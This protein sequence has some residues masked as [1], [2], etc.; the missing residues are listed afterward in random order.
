MKVTA[1]RHW[2]VDFGFYNAIYVRIETDEGVVG[3]AEVAMRRRTRSVA[4]LVEELGD[5][6]VGQDPMRIEQLWERMYRDAFLGGTLL[7]VGISAIDMALWDLNGR[8]LGAPVHRLL[9]GRFRDR[10][11]IYGHARAGGSP[12]EFAATVRT[13]AD[14]GF[15]AVKTTLPGFYQK[16]TSMHHEVPAMV[17][18]RHTETEILPPSIF[19]TIA[20]WFAAAR[21]AVGPHFQIGLDCHGR[22]SVANAIRLCEALEPYDLLFVEE[23]TPFERPD[24]LREVSQATSIPIAAGERWG[25]HHTSAPFLESHSVAIAQPDVSL[26][27]GLT[28]GRKIAAIAEAHAIAIAFHNPFGPLTSAATMHLAAVLPNLLISECMAEPSQQVLWERY[29]ED[30]PRIENGEWVVPDTPGLGTRL[31]ID[32]LVKHPPNLA[33]DRGGTR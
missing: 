15:R 29:T 31:R 10:V 11:P 33:Y 16:W 1:V 25:A 24:W 4:A 18:A 21:E 17:P 27:G 30:P 14:R 28:S 8:A 19:R 26:C 13:W 3:E 22:L 2:V 20:E 5:E 23:P 7:L 32:E 12:E 6:L 9:G